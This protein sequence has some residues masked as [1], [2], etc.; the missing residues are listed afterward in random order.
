MNEFE[1]LNLAPVIFHLWD[2]KFNETVA[3]VANLVKTTLEG[4]I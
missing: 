2:L 1:A 4:L 3:L